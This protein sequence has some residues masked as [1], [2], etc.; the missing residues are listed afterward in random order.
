MLRALI[1]RVKFPGHVGRS[2]GSACQFILPILTRKAFFHAGSYP[3]IIGFPTGTFIVHTA[4]S[5]V[6]SES[7][8]LQSV[9]TCTDLNH[10]SAS[11]SF[12]AIIVWTF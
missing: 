12:T 5:G 11:V 3:S 4:H 10:S 6:F 9:S 2:Q 8:P 7:G 1:D